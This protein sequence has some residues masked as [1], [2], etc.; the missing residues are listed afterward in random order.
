MSIEFRCTH[1][2][3]LLRTP[4]D[5]AGRRSVC[6]KCGWQM[7]VP[8]TSSVTAP[9]PYAAP[10]DYEPAPAPVGSS[11][12]HMAIASLILGIVSLCFSCC[13][14]VGL[15]SAVVGLGLGIKGLESRH[16]G[17]AIAGIVL[18]VLGL[19]ANA[20]LAV[21]NMLIKGG[22]IQGPHAVP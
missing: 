10:E 3:T 2:Q 17:I 5:A 12:E 15:P 18:S 6:P 22:V 20:G 7:D 9:N 11:V 1:C 13:C 21:I 19:L 14:F 16:R 8:Y 4:D